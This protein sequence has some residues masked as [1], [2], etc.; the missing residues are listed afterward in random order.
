MHTALGVAVCAVVVAVRP[1]VAG[2]RTSVIIS[3]ALA[4]GSALA[5]AVYDRLVYGRTLRHALAATALPI[6]AIAAFVVVLAGSGDLSLRI[7]AGIVTALIIGG[8]PHLGGLRAAGREGT[9]IRLVRD[10]AGVVVLAPILLAAFSDSI[11][12]WSSAALAGCA[13]ALVTFDALL[14]E[15]L[16]GW[17]AA[18]AALFVATAF[19]ALA[20]A[21]PVAG[22]GTLRAALLLVGWY[23]LRGIAGVL[24]SRSPRRL[25]L[26]GE[27][28]VF[29]LA[30]AGAIAYG[31]VRG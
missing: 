29:V 30:A 24:P 12:R 2:L 20:W 1:Q 26:A 6:A 23:G 28:A 11:A 16:R 19:A 31:A 10:G 27:Y 25:A 14:T 3:G 17:V 15:Q 7:P 5:L 21:M 18:L 13:V 22:H 9:F 8:L 4:V